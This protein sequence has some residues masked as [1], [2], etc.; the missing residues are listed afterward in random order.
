[1]EMASI[2]TDLAKSILEKLIDAT[3]VQSGYICCFTCIAKEF[4]KEKKTLKAKRTTVGEYVKVANRR[5]EGIRSDVIFWQEQVDKLIQEDTKTR[6]TCFSGWCPNCKWQYSRGK[7]LANKTKKIKRLM[8]SNFESVGIPR[9]VAGVEYHSSQ[10]YISFK[11]R[12][13]KCKE[14]LDALTNDNN[15]MTGLQGMGGTGK[16]T[17][18]KEVGKELKKSEKFDHVIDATVSYA[19]D[20]KKIQDEIAGPLGLSLEYCTEPEKPKTLWSRLI[21]GEK[22]LLILDDVWENINFEDIGIP[23]NDNHNGCRI[24]ITTCNLRTC[25]SMRCDRIIQLELLPEEDAWILFKKRAGISDSSS[26][27][28]LDKGRKI[29]KECK[30]LPIA[31]AVIASS[32]KGEQRPEE[33]NVALKSLQDCSL[34][35]DDEN[36]GKIYKC[37]R[38]SYDNMNNEKATGLFLL[39]SMFREDQE[40]SVEILTRFSVGVGLVG[41]IDDNYD[42]GRNEVVVAKNKLIDSCLLLNGESGRVK[43]HDLVREVALLIANEEIK[44]VNTSN[45][46]EKSLVEKAKNLK[47]L[48]CEGKSMDVF[49]LKFDGSKLGILIVYLD[50]DENDSVEVPNSFFENIIGLRVLYLSHK[51]WIWRKATLSLPQSIQSLTNIRSLYLERFDLGDIS[52]LGNLRG[53]ETLDLVDCLMDELPPEFAELKKLKLLNLD[54]CYIRWSNPFKVIESCSS[55]EELHFVRSFPID[56]LTMHQKV[57]LPKL[58]RFRIVDECPFYF[59]ADWSGRNSLSISKV[60]VFF[61][62]VTFKHL[63]QTTEFLNLFGLQGGWR[64]LIPEIIL[65]EYEGTLNL[66]VLCLKSIS[67]LECLVDTKHIDSRVQNVFSKL[68]ELRLEEMENLKELYSGPLPFELMKSLETL[69]VR[70]CIHLGGILFKSK[71]TLC[72]L[73]S[74]SLNN[75]PM[76]TSLFQLSTTQSLVLLERLFIEN[77]EQMKSI[78]T[79]ERTRED[80]EE[81]IVDDDNDNKSAGS[82]FPNLKTLQIKRCPQLDFILPM[83]AARDVPKLED[84]E[85]RDC[86]ELKYIFDTYQNKHEEQDLQQELKDVIFVT[87][88]KMVL[89]GLPNFVDIFPECDQSM[90]SSVK[91]LCSKDDS[92][93]QIES[94]PIKCNILP[95]INCKTTKIPL[96]SKDQLQGCFLSSIHDSKVNDVIRQEMAVTF[97][98]SDMHQMT[99]LFVVPNIYYTLKNVTVLRITN[100]ERMEVIFSASMLRCLPQLHILDISGCNGLKQI[101]EEDTRNQRM[102]YF[103][104]PQTLFPML[105]VLVIEECNNLKCVFPIST[106]KIF[107]KLEFLVIKKACMLEEVFKCESDQKVEIS[108]LKIAVFVELPSLFQEIEFQTVKDRLVQNCPKLS[109]TSTLT[110]DRIRQIIYSGMEACKN[111]DFEIVSQATTKK[112]PTLKAKVQKPSFSPADEESSSSSYEDEQEVQ[113][114][115]YS[116]PSLSEALEKTPPQEAS[117]E[118]SS[119][120]SIDN[121]KRVPKYTAMDIDNCLKKLDDDP[122][123]L[124]DFMSREVSMSPKQHK[125]NVQQ[126]STIETLASALL[127]LRTLAFS[128]SMMKNIGKVE[129]REKVEAAIRKLDKFPKDTDQ[130][131]DKRIRSFIELFKKAEEVCQ[132]QSSTVDLIK[133]ADAE[134]KEALEKL[135]TTKDKVL[136]LDEAIEK[137]K[138]KLEDIEKRQKEVKDAMKKLQEELNELDKDKAKLESENTECSSKKAELIESVKYVSNAL[139]KTSKHLVDLEKTKAKHDANFE[140]LKDPYKKMKANPPF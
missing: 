4:E 111:I 92:E 98:L 135:Q 10:D 86:V 42:A 71:L 37:L 90:H 127:E 23:Y 15:Y 39:C 32:I 61:S 70:N 57:K 82:M 54:W 88:K 6:M 45:K 35:G 102:S 27:S 40:F 52:I 107:S 65:P 105:K 108:N 112:E 2:A 78:I 8:E 34:R 125:T 104:S 128:Q 21:N 19:P 97:Q 47:Y 46:N 14:L 81:E 133:Q 36:L 44:A 20:I 48:L 72:N 24:L 79:D 137:R 63:V 60:D 110:P 130:D 31:I 67:Q 77:C 16:T 9:A 33:W 85:I 95:W 1:M 139:G 73:K 41:E 118:Q 103:L 117:K 69:Y 83:V 140:A 91:K 99:C 58:H 12:E 29:A 53:L 25:N 11:S 75:C 80:L 115:N 136:Q 138:P 59:R 123:A 43:M 124:L 30:G 5:A 68:I 101:I 93:T 22:I 122:F 100:C 106:S 94:D 109:L 120:E 55:L 96:H 56:R 129:Y 119:N 121:N 49:S 116:T 62:E 38:Y 51:T 13:L 126:S 7:D 64:N 134:K 89:N 3:I 113:G 76:L 17:L 26:K 28:I 87:L 131:L 114:S 132:E 74:M 50:G 66:V 84:I 18:A